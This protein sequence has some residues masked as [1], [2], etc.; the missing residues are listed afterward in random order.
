MVERWNLVVT[1]Q[2]GPQCITIVITLLPGRSSAETAAEITPAGVRGHQ[3][4]NCPKKKTQRE[5]RVVERAN[6]ECASQYRPATL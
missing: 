5:V 1:V 2:T 3:E 4:V 6:T